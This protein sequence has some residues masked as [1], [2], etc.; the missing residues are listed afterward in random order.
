[1]KNMNDF[2]KSLSG[3]IEEAS[4]ELYSELEEQLQTL[5]SKDDNEIHGI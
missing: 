4:M 5:I 3:Y 1:M 2:P